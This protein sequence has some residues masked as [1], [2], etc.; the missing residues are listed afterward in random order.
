MLI[1]LYWERRKIQDLSGR[2][3]FFPGNQRYVWGKDL[4]FLCWN[5]YHHLHYFL[6]VVLAVD[7]WSAGVILLSLLSGRYPFF[8][9]NDD[10]TCLSQIIS[11]LGT[12]KV[13]ESAKT[14]GKGHLDTLYTNT[15]TFCHFHLFRPRNKIVGP[16]TLTKFF[17]FSLSSGGKLFAQTLFGARCPGNVIK[18]MP[19]EEINSGC[20]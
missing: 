3:S 13:Q 8:R 9:S 5:N 7:M 17:F 18:T 12:E 6:S 2:C 10:L 16:E 15:L 20:V 11:I 1:S 19:A 14:Y 4:Y